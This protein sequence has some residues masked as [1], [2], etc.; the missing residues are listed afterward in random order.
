MPRFERGHAKIGGRQ[1]GQSK[2]KVAEETAKRLGI[3]PF[4][5]LCLF[6]KGDWME[7]RINK[8]DIRPR[9]RLEAAKEACKYIYA[10]KRAVEISNPDGTGFRVQ[11]VDYSSKK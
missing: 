7:L 5:V 6:A 8:D 9:D 4:E 1:K 3:D 2:H 11:V 10:Q